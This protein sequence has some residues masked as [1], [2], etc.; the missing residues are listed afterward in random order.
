MEYKQSL[1]ILKTYQTLFANVRVGGFLSKTNSR[2]D[3]DPA[4]IPR[5]SL[6]GDFGALERYLSLSAEYRVPLVRDL[7]FSIMGLYF[8]M[9]TFAPFLDAFAFND[10][11]VSLK[12]ASAF[13]KSALTTGLAGRQRVYFMGKTVLNLNLQLYYDLKKSD[14]YGFVYGVTGETGF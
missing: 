14:S 3:A 8:Q 7:G 6:L 9:F 11:G 5:G 4:L 1:E 10:A 13:S 2:L 12:D